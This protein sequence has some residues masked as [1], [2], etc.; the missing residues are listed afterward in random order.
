MWTL[1]ALSGALVLGQAPVTPAPVSYPFVPTAPVAATRWNAPDTSTPGAPAA[2][3]PTGAVFYQPDARGT[4]TPTPQN[5]SNDE[6]SKNGNGAKKEEP[7]EE[8][9][10]FFLRL[11]QGVQG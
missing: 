9:H 6:P 11:L 8:V 1:A 4:P 3:P 5:G 7:K 2:L 10:G